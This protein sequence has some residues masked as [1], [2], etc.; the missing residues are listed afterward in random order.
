MSQLATLQR[1]VQR[2]SKSPD[3]K[4]ALSIIVD[5]VMEAMH[6]DACSVFLRSADAGGLTL[7]A[8]NGLKQELVNQLQM[9]MDQGLVGLV[10]QRAEPVN[11]ANASSHARYSLIENSG[12]ENYQAFLG[13]PIVD[14]RRLYGVLVVQSVE[15]R[16]YSE[17]DTAFLVTLGAQ[18]AAAISA[19]ELSGEIASDGGEQHD[20]VRINGLPGAPGVAIGKALLLYAKADLAEVP[21]R[22][23][24]D[25]AKEKHK[26]SEA[27]KHVK[28]DM[29][30]LKVK[31]GDSVSGETA[32]LFDAY[33][34][35]LDSD[36][37]ISKIHACIDDGD[38]VQGAL[39]KSIDEYSQV[40]SEMDDEYL[41]ERVVDIRDMGRR[42]LEYLS[43]DVAEEDLQYSAETVLIGHDISAS[44]LAEVPREKLA[45]LICTTG[46]QSSHVAILA[47]ALGVPTVMGASGLPLNQLDMVEV[48]VDGYAGQICIKPSNDV[49]Q[50]YRL[51]IQEEY[52]LSEQLRQ[53][54]IQPAITKD[55]VRLPVF[56]N[57]GLMSDLSQDQRNY[58]DGLGLYRTEL[59]FMVRDS[60]PT[61]DEQEEIY[62]RVMSSYPDL[63]VTLRTLDVGGDKALR[64]FPIKEENPFL[65]WRGVRI[66]LDHPEIFLTQLRAMLRA[67]EKHK[68][69]HILLPMIS[70]MSELDE[71]LALISMARAELAENGLNIP[72]PKI[73]VMI[74]VPSAVYIADRIAEKVDFL[75]IGSND[76]IQYLLAVDRNNAKVASLYSDLHPSFLMALQVIIEKAHSVDTPVSICGEMAS[77]PVLVLLL[78]GLGLDSLSV[79]M[80]SLPSVKWVLSEFSREQA[81]QMV[82]DAMALG[83]PAKIREMLSQH[84]IEAGL[85]A[86]VRAG[87]H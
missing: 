3:L 85:G 65:G 32:V 56:I 8:T 83:N 36:T 57:S 2:V 35:M 70:T 58:C 39:R 41:S 69:L 29:Q 31:M 6:S 71:S 84:L 82:E 49:R 59:P 19:A 68:N 55:G 53:V 17:D 52:E 77:D 54:A 74:E 73:G 42:I 76:L 9:T 50:S 10:A 87:K 45:G 21:D 4:T 47:R 11:L 33:S 64:Y 1:I 86:L 40:F 34:M 62:S 44:Q 43:K 14:H 23:H 15:Q 67:S 75:S 24:E 27:I 20:D 79:S 12:D 16:E 13:V 81:E 22:K 63:P 61:E 66:T 78:L 38:W 46:T 26:L 28:Q 80:A 18:L 25:A 7:R 37:L 48:V 5:Q 60:F 51:L 72:V 30:T